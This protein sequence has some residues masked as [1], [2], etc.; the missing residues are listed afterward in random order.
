MGLEKRAQTIDDAEEQREAQN[1]EV[2]ELEEDEMSR[3]HLPNRVRVN[4]A[5][6]HGKGHEVVRPNGGLEIEVGNDEGPDGEEGEEAEEGAAGF[7][8]AGATGADDV[9]GGLEG[10]PDEHDGALH[11]VPLGE[12]EIVEPFGERQGGGGEAE[13]GEHGLLPEGGSAFVAGEGVDADE[14]EDAFDGA[15]DDAEG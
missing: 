6:E 3:N 15:V 5:S 4:D 7:V 10:V 2:G 8:A 12:G 9:L 11:H 14:E 13:G 1:V